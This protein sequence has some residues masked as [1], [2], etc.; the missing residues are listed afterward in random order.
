MTLKTRPAPR[1]ATYQQDVHL[2]WSG[3][4]PDV[5]PNGAKRVL[6][7][8]GYKDFAPTELPR[9]IAKRPTFP[10]EQELIPTVE[11]HS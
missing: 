7:G 11:S 2:R 3:P 1:G 5:A 4:K 8:R 10:D 6:F 9:S